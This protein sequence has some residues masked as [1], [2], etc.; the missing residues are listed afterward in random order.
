MRAVVALFDLDSPAIWVSYDE[1]AP[2]LAF[3][4]TAEHLGP[5]GASAAITASSEGTHTPTNVL[6]A[7]RHPAAIPGAEAGS[8]AMCTPPISPAE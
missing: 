3:L 6:P 7:A 4:V 8:T 1:A 5:S 2:P